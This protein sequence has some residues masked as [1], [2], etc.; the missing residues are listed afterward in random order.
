[1]VPADPRGFMSS[2]QP[3]PSTPSDLIDFYR[4][5]EVENDDALDDSN[6][7]VGRRIAQAREM[8][9]MTQEQLSEHL[10]VR[11]A[12]VRRWEDGR[13]GPR[14]NRTV[15]IAGLLGVS[16][17]WLMMG[18]GEAP[19]EGADLD[20]IRLD[21]LAL[22]RTLHGA[23]QEVDLIVGRLGLLNEPEA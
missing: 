20:A 12:T 9:G 11:L 13:S 22:R 10:G 19:S 6:L 21:V 18:R 16:I 8:A 14:A 5:R 23:L 2:R 3:D 1:M 15:T 17:S 4:N 7:A